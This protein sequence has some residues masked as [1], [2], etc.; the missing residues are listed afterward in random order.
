MRKRINWEEIRNKYI[1]GIKKD[2]KIEFPTIQDLAKE[3]ST[4]PA[5]IG[6]HSSKDGW[7]KAREQ[8]LNERRIK[9]EQKVAEAFAEKTVPF[10]TQ[11]L[12]IAQKLLDKIGERVE[13]IGIIDKTSVYVNLSGA[14]KQ[15]MEVK[16]FILGEGGNRGNDRTSDIEQRIENLRSAIES[17]KDNDI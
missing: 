10:D 15:L 6:E 4:S 13:V 1:C 3:Y 11:T 7:V 16:K 12:N 8:Y 2:G 9:G 17:S 14:L 5:T